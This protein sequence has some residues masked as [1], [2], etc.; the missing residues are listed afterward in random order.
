MFLGR[1]DGKVWATVKEERLRGIQLSIMQPLDEDENPQGKPMIV[2][3][4]IGATDGDLVYWVNSTEASFVLED[5]LIP[6]E[7]SVVGLVDRLDLD[8]SSLAT[9]KGD[10]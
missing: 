6:S 1:I 7:A 10:R 8:R 3:D 9:H 5:S 2:V 4:T